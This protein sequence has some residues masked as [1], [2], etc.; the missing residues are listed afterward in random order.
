MQGCAGWRINTSLGCLLEH[1][2]ISTVCFLSRSLPPS[3]SSLRRGVFQNVAA[4]RLPIVFDV[5]S[6]IDSRL[7]AC[8]RLDMVARLRASSSSNTY[9]CVDEC[10]AFESCAV[11]KPVA[12]YSH[13]G[14]LYVPCSCY[15]GH[16]SLF[17][18]LYRIRQ[19][20]TVG[21][22]KVHA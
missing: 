2:T 13:T 17:S 7:F 18:C 10:V 21:I 4:A 11:C 6:I 14:Q 19:Q 3:H 9:R 1:I 20:A 16:A 12:R 8:C 15:H 5:T 22:V